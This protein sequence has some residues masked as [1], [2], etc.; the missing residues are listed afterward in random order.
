MSE[1]ALR[2]RLQPSLLDRLIDDERVLT[3]YELTFERTRLEDLG[4]LE[5]D[6][7]AVLATQGLTQVERLEE[8]GWLV[9]RC[10]APAGRIGVSQL[11]TLAVSP[12]VSFE[13][14]GRIAARNVL[15]DA[16]ET[17]ERRLAVSRRLREL[18]GRDLSL[19]LNASSLEVTDEL[20]KLPNVRNSVLNFG[21][22]PYT[23]R[24][25]SSAERDRLSR[26]L[27]LAIRRFEPRLMKV[28]VTPEAFDARTQDQELSFRIDAQLWGQ[29]APHQI[30][31]RTRIDTESGKAHISDPGSL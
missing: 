24:A 13:K 23:G 18:V 14:I 26:A 12:G 1:L 16:A 31:L 3:V 7:R 5:Q 21:V 2:E 19:L 25:A 11:A 4:V 28:R 10:R 6:L 22:P 29:P 30:V 9:L 20:E 17:P 15:N 8:G 27:E